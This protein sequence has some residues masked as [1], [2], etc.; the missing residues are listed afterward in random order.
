MSSHDLTSLFRQVAADQG[1]AYVGF[2]RAEPLEEEAKRLEEWLNQGRH[3][4]MSYLENHFDKR[5]DPRQLV[6]GAK[7]V[8]SLMYNYHN[9][10]QQAAGAPKLS[11]YA[12]GEDYHYVIKRKLKTL[13]A[14]LEDQV[15]AITGR[16]FVDSAPVLERDWATR[17]GVGWV[18]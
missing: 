3:G 1:F 16:V 8:I 14:W 10:A 4:K 5:I 6:P 13:V 17:A 15:G 2:A 11:Q 9:P 12:Y 18:G 7:T